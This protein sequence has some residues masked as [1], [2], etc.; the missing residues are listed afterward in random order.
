ML[1]AISGGFAVVPAQANDY[2]EVILNGRVMDPET[3]YDS[4]A[5]VGIK[6][7]RISG[8]LHDKLF[9]LL[10]PRQSAGQILGSSR[11]RDDFTGEQRQIA[12]LT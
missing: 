3:M 4:V 6:D 10:C 7:G 1:L 5:N 12:F 8:Y 2:D 11:C 9:G